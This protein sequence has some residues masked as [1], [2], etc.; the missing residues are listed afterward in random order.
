MQV[1]RAC[2]C[3]IE[4]VGEPCGIVSGSRDVVNEASERKPSR[5]LQLTSARARTFERSLAPC[6]SSSTS[7]LHKH[8]RKPS[9]TPQLSSVPL[10]PLISTSNRLSPLFAVPLCVS[11]DLCNLSLP[12]KRYCRAVGTSEKLCE[13]STTSRTSISYRTTARDLA[14]R[15]LPSLP[16]VATESLARDPQEAVKC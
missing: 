10:I 12:P 14:K 16:R 9:C 5:P 7:A 1:D 4:G 11:A 6:P 15:A 2:C 13:R 3:T 8:R